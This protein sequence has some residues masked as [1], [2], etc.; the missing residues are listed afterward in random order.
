MC[1]FKPMGKRCVSCGFEFVRESLVEAV[2]GH[3]REV[4]IGR[5]KLADNHRHLYEQVVTYARSVGNPATAK[6]RAAHLFKHMVGQFPDGY[7][8]ER[9]HNVPITRGVMNKIREKQIA[10]RASQ[11]TSRA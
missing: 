5:T 7:S 2:P 3:M 6:G 4:V 10:W 8:Y 11:Q 1:S 9:T